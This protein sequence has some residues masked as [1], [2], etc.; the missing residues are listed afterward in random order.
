MGNTVAA[1]FGKYNPP[2]VYGVQ[3]PS[4]NWDSKHIDDISYYIRKLLSLPR[5]SP[6]NKKERMK[7]V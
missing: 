1:I 7:I 2:Y 6:K 3:F 4:V 5:G